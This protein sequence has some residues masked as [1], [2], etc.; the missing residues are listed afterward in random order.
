MFL[1]LKNREYI[2]KYQKKY[3]RVLLILFVLFP[4]LVFSQEIKSLHTSKHKIG[5]DYGLGKNNGLGFTAIDIDRDYEVHLLQFQYYRSLIRYKTFGLEAVGQ[6]QINFA[7]F[8]TDSGSKKAIEFGLNI[9]LLFRFI[10][11]NE[12]LSIYGLI[13][14]GPHFISKTPQRQANNFIFSDNFF[15]GINYKISEG[16]YVDVRPGKRHVSNLDLQSPN[17]GINTFVLNIGIMKL[18]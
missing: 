9:G 13:S 16:L 15:G 11:F 7:K 18:L 4:V 17:G 12:R 10:F 5:F 3:M 1:F 6:P 2:E 14:S 8:K